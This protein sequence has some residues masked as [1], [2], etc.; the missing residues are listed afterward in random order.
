M[1]VYSE[2]ADRILS[3]SGLLTRSEARRAAASGRVTLNGRRIKD[4]SVKVTEKDVLC[5]DGEEIKYSKYLYILLNKPE[6]YVCSTDERDGIPVM[7]IFGDIFGS[8]RISP[9]GRLDKNTTG[10]LLLT[11]DGVLGHMLLAPS[12]HV[13][14]VYEC[15]CEKPMRDSYI[16]SFKEGVD[17]GEARPTLPSELAITG[18]HTA[19]LTLREGKFHQVKRMFEAVGNRITALHRREFASLCDTGLGI[20]EWRFL[21]GGEVEHLFE[22]C[23]KTVQ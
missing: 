14:K 22:I 4:C 7:D 17:I 23:G 5:L 8:H 16:E 9:V 12:K 13:D 2:R 6:G 11:D 19:L 21:Q 15:T 18:E 20:G 10:V 1:E 3:A